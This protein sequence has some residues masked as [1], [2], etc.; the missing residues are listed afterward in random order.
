MFLGFG[1][2]SA[3][4]VSSRDCMYSMY[5]KHGGL[6]RGSGLWVRRGPPPASTKCVKESPWLVEDLAQV[7]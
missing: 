7:T 4:R 5:R 2:G 3:E 6:H 1:A